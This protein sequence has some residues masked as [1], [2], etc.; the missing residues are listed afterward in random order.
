MDENAA[1]RA[2]AVDQIRNAQRSGLQS[3]IAT[4]PMGDTST[5]PKVNKTL[6]GS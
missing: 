3:N 2:A 4:S 1:G 6:L 5:T